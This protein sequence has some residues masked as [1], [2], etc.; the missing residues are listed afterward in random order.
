MLARGSWVEFDARAVLAPTF[1]DQVTAWTALVKE[2]IVSV[3]EMRAAILHLPP[4]EEGD[5]LQ[6]LTEPPTANA[7]PSPAPETAEEAIVTELRPTA[8]VTGL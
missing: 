3:N 7:S 6:D 2:G 8:M 1:Q 5:A 4:T